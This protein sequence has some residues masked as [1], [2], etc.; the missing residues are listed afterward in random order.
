MNR[1]KSAPGLVVRHWPGE[2]TAVVLVQP[3]GVTHLVEVEALEIVHAAAVQPAGMSLR[4]IAH[5]LGLELAADPAI[6]EDLQRIIEGL[7]QSGLLQRVEDDADPG[8]DAKR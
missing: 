7:I 8:A 6:G 4:E 2:P 3:A 1:F 5:A